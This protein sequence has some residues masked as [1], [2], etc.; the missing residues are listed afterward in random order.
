MRRQVHAALAESIGQDVD[1]DRRAWHR[2]HAAAGPD[3]MVAA[4]LEASAERAQARGGLAA[5]AAFLDRAVALTP[6]PA[7]RARRALAAAQAAHASGSADAALALLATAQDGPLDELEDARRQLLAAQIAFTTRR[8]REAASALVAAA[9]R[10]ESLDRTLAR[11]TYLEAIWAASFS[12][13]AA[14][15]SSQL[16]AGNGQVEIWAAARAAPSMSE[17]R[18]PAD[19]ML[20]GLASRFADGYR[21][22][23][24][25]LQRALSA[26]RREGS[27]GLGGMPWVW[28]ALDLWDADAWLELGERQVRTSRDA[29]AL[30]VLP[31]ALHTVAARHLL[32]GELELAGTLIREA[33]SIISAT[34]HVP[35]IHAGLGLAALQGGPGR[36]FITSTIRD[37]TE[38]G[39]GILVRHAQHALAMLGNALGRYD[40]ALRAAQAE[41]EH[42]PAG[43]V[44]TA[45]PELVE[46]AARSNEPELARS[47]LDQ[48]SE[49]TQASGTRWARGVEA[50]SRALLSDGREA[51]ALYRR[52]IDLLDGQRLGLERARA[53]LVYGEFLRREGQRRD[54]RRELRSAHDWFTEAGAGPFTER[55]NRELRAC[56]AR[57]RSEREEIA[58]EL[59]T[60]EA[61]IAR[62][63]GSGVSNP[64][65]GAQLFISPRTVEYHLAKVYAKLGITSRNQ[66]AEA[67][68]DRVNA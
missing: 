8:G 68:P 15:F 17:P 58:G 30:T 11:A 3:E 2:A 41:L 27:H 45:L 65:I 61:D 34:G 54:A 63:A 26:F 53:Q 36:A 49:Q 1:P 50:R 5:A 67:L 35:L 20:D 59:T 14:S 60:R 10:V 47:A 33:D 66:L 38:R 44:M 62:L 9:R 46:A 31:L 48:L 28:L 16:G 40:E 51:D 19:L 64:E 13:W 24:P 22:G 7:R 12:S 18:S 23:A 57:P 6:D 55:A 37:G 42:N 52:A 25:T 56:G 29:G 4:Q 39:G 43:F 21:A 32:A